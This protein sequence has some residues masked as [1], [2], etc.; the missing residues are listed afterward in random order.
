MGTYHQQLEREL[1]DFL[2]VSELSLMVNGHMS[3]EMAIQAMNFPEGSEVITT[4]FTF[5]STTHA[6]VR[7]RLQPVFCDIKLTDYTIDEEKIEELITPKTVAIVPVHVYG[8][9]CNVEKLQE[10][11]YKYN[12]KLIYDAA[13]AFGETYKGQGVGG[14]GDASIFSFHAT[15]VFN[16]IEGGAVASSSRELYERLYDL[17]NF[18][19][20]SEELVKEVGANAKMNEF[21][22]AMGLCNLP[23][24]KENISLRKERALYY[25]EQLKD[26]EGVRVP[27]FDNEDIT[28]N[29]A[30]YPVVF[31]P[32][33]LGVNARDKIYDVLKE[34]DIFAR[35]YFYPLTADDACFKNKYQSVSLVN[36]KKISD[37][38][39]VLPLY[40][41]LEFDVLDEISEIIKRKVYNII[42]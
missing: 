14:F 40:P 26:V 1:K 39:L 6:I 25:N 37:N 10:I 42:R 28:Y 9:I 12:L 41:E 22:A 30:Y 13:H 24:V 27:L 32:D 3:L 33:I 15:K 5:V 18:G 20:R 2:G 29:Y 8:N 34:N 4:P 38:V 17:K 11:A 31:D 19:I 23:Y 16:T 7:N 36:A 21:C 35:K